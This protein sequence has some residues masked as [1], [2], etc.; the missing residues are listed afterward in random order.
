VAQAHE[1]VDVELVVGEQH[2]V[3]EPLRRRA[4]VVAQAVQ[5]VVDPRG[6]EERQRLRLAV[7]RLESAVGDA[8]V[9][10][11]QVGQVEHVAHEG[12]ALGAHGAFDVV[13]LGEGEVDRYRLGAG[14]HLELDLVVLQQQP[15]LVEVVAR[16]QVGARER[17]LVAAGAG[18]EAVAQPG[19]GRRRVARDGVGVD[20]HEGVAGPH[21]PRQF[22]AGDEA[23]HRFAQMGQAAVVDGLDL[24][25]RGGGVGEAGGGDECGHVGHAGIVQCGCLVSQ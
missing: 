17:G 22:L 4:R 14:A 3:L 12:A 25:E 21:P 18:H 15:E 19:V 9:H 23:Q 20:P 2:E 13:V 24:F 7:A 11:A 6:G 10:H 5:R 16:E 1:F 8:V